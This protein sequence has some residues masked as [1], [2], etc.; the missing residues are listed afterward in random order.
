LLRFVILY[1]SRPNLY[2]C[3]RA[4]VYVSARVRDCV[5]HRLV[6]SAFVIFVNLR[7]WSSWIY[8]RDLLESAFVIFSNLRLWLRSWICFRESVWMHLSF[9]Q[10]LEVKSKTLREC[11]FKSASTCTWNPDCSYSNFASP[12]TAWRA[13]AGIWMIL[14]GLDKGEVFS[15]YVASPGASQGM[16]RYRSYRTDWRGDEMWQDLC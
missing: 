8:V 15:C 16:L 4:W 3:L 1:V 7:S 6:W 11:L 2:M 5:C 13:R 14:R 10:Y 12:N 9:C